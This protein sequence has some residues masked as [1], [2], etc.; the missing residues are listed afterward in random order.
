MF[1]T[2]PLL[3]KR[4][5]EKQHTWGEFVLFNSFFLNCNL[6]YKSIDLHYTTKLFSDQTQYLGGSFQLPVEAF[7]LYVRPYNIYNYHSTKE[8]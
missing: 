6:V 1:H 3:A 7:M 5:S 2:D 8:N 4:S